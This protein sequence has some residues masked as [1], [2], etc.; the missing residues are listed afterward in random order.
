MPKTIET[1]DIDTKEDFEIA[2]ILYK[3]FKKNL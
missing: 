3:K 1:F 2:K